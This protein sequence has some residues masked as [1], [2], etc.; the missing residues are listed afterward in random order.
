MHLWDQYFHISVDVWNLTAALLYGLL[1][2]RSAGWVVCILVNNHPSLL[3]L[4]CVCLVSQRE[5]MVRTFY[6]HC[7]ENTTRCLA[8]IREWITPICRGNPWPVYVQAAHLSWEISHHAFSPMYC[9]YPPRKLSYVFPLV[10]VDS[11]SSVACCRIR[12]CTSWNK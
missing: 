11:C 12:Q 9:T 5:K 1:K 4:R 3:C 6:A 2:W 7:K 10:K 8:F